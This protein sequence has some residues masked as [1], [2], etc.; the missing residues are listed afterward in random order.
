MAPE[1]VLGGAVDGRSDL[2]A[3]GCVAYYL[4]TG[5]LVFEAENGLQAIVKHINDAPIPP[6]ERTGVPL[7]RDLEEVV[8]A[9]LAKRPADRPGSAAQLSR[10]FRNL[11]LEPWTQDDAVRWWSGIQTA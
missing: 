3:L 11:A 8:L 6:S 9:C 5:R 1:M 10:R 2:Y 7:P 4:L